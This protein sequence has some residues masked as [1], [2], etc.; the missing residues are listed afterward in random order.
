MS[1]NNDQD[2]DLQWLNALRDEKTNLP[3]AQRVGAALRK[4]HTQMAH[5]VLSSK[6][7]L[8]RIERRL[9]AEK[10]LQKDAKLGHLP[11]KP[12]FLHASL[13]RW[14]F[15]LAL[16]SALGFLIWQAPVFIANHRMEQQEDLTAYRGLDVSKTTRAFT[17][18][19]FAGYQ[20]QI[21]KDL[22]EA[23]SQWRAALIEANLTH[24]TH[25]STTLANAIEIHIR[26]AAGISKLDGINVLT[27]APQYGEWVVYLIPEQR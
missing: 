9:T 14:G 24:S 22:N 18:L 19:P 16:A 6:E 25:R 17:D 12:S 1:Q 26:L 11:S 3:D 5:A 27:D 10:L 7:E 20:F 2:E 8:D 15:G 13:P 23:E 21:V 4:R